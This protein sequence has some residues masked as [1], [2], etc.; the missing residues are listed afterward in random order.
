MHF[1]TKTMIYNSTTGD[2][3]ANK[4]TNFGA[5]KPLNFGADKHANFVT[6]KHATQ[7]H[8][9]NTEIFEGKKFWGGIQL[10]FLHDFII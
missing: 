3:G 1:K 9:G 8:L 6:N 7:A 10:V 5:N 4:S 2:F